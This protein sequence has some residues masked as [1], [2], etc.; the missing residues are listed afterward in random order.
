MAR[1]GIAAA[2]L[3]AK[4]GYSVTINDIKYEI[5]L[6]DQ[7]NQLYHKVE[8]VLGCTPDG[9]LRGRD[10]VV[11]SPGI[12]THLPFFQKA[13][14]L[15]IPIISEIELGYHYT[16]G[17]ITAITGTNGKTTTTALVGEIFK[18]AGRPTIVAGNIGRAMTECVGETSVQSEMVLE[19]SSF[20]LEAI[21]DF[22]PRV[23][24]VL[25]ITPDH[26][27]RH[28]DMEGYITAKKRIFENQRENDILILNDDNALTREIAKDATCK[29]MFFSRT[30]EVY[31]GSCIR[32]DR[33]VFIDEGIET[34]ITSPDEVRIRGQHNQENAL[35]AVA[36]ACARGIEP[37][38]IR[39]TLATFEGVEHRL[40]SVDK[41]SNVRFINDSKG[42]NPD[43]TIR[44]VESMEMPT[45]LILGGYDKGV[46]FDE[47]ISRFTKYIEGVVV[48]GDTAQIIAENL[49]VRGYTNYQYGE[50]FK[51]A[52]RKAFAMARPGYNVLLSPACASFD[53]F[54]DFEERGRVFKGIVQT[55]KEEH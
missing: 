37:H 41:V 2:N 14:E 20:Q 31:C 47:L 25:N 28:G 21:R 44:A 5:D 46:S 13:R 8:Y 23:S 10:F 48:L 34:I 17:A 35:A 55:L 22:C 30:H 24:A 6:Q 11:V 16:K 43:A 36:M 3:L 18:K 33:I 45:I 9:L 49:D 4:E 40:E 53:M 39:H 7:I 42:T 19:V 1:S 15:G 51:S 32:N 12:P 54:K 52:V 27:D 26:L 38:I 50:D 29:V